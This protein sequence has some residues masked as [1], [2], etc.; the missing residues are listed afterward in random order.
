MV[1]TAAR[2]QWESLQIEKTESVTENGLAHE[3]LWSHIRKE[4][5]FAWQDFYGGSKHKN[6][7]AVGLVDDF[8]H[9]V[10]AK[11]FERN[12]RATF[13]LKSESNLLGARRVIQE[14]NQGARKLKPI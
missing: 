11:T 4:A 10:V 13:Y 2:P 8:V 1:L 14:I 5:V 9:F 6:S 12:D 3:F 7:K